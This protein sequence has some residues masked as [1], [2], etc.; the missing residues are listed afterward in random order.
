M[1]A[2]VVTVALLAGGVLAQQKN[3]QDIDLQAAI[4]TETVDGDLNGAIKQYGAIVSK[5]K[6]DR[7]VAATALVRMAGCYQKLGDAQARTI[8]ER[9]VREFGD[10]RDAVEQ[11]RARLGEQRS[12]GT[13]MVARQLWTTTFYSQVTIANDGRSAAVAEPSSRD[14]QIRDFTTGQT[15][16]LKVT[17]NPASGAYAEWPVLSP[18]LKQVAYAY[19]GPETK[20]NYQVRIA[21][22]QPDAKARPVGNTSPYLYV[23]GWSPDGRSVLVTILAEGNN[24]Q[25][26]W[27]STTDGAV[28]TLKS[29]DWQDPER[30][31]LSPDGKFIAYAVMVEQGKPDREIRI[32]ASD[33]SSESVV[34]RAPGINASPVWSRDGSRLVFM[35]D[36]SGTLGIWSVA[37]RNGRGDG[38]PTRLKADVGDIALIGFDATGSLLYEHTIGMRDVFAMDL[39]SQAGK[40]HGDAVRLLDTFL[41]WNW[42]PAASPDG[43]SL[44][45]LSRRNGTLNYWANLVVR[46]LETGAERVIPTLFRAAGAGG[47]PVWLPDGQSII[48]PARNTQGHTILYKVDLKS[49]EIATAINTASQTPVT[50]AISPD[51]RTVY[52]LASGAEH[53]L[54]AAYD[55]A[56][57]RRTDV[58]HAGNAKSVAASPDGRSIAFVAWESAR[59][60]I[61]A[62][63]TDGRNVHAIVTTERPDERPSGLAGGLS[64]SP[65]S[66]FVFFLQQDQGSLWRVAAIGGA[67]ALVGELTKDPVRTIDVTRD[68]RR[69]IFSTDRKGDSVEVWALDNVLPSSV[70]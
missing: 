70:R 9:V 67:A 69:V 6:A 46:S 63:D 59:W 60:H 34:A 2:F 15:T 47:T 68:G 31:A 40:I 62:A 16:R 50:A 5:Y 42:N 56:S 17:P 13:G 55:L 37:V 26:A 30:L 57:G 4:R 39:D 14:V 58:S 7:G 22:T 12:T 36:R 8:Y 53:V 21:A 35:S 24:F 27:M 32:L 18:D 61:Y 25:I 3:Q 43:K 28:R 51:G 20:F 38:S 52:A 54:V 45:Y 1:T 10:Q 29:L 19:A 44:A 23:M 48:Q 65:D 66:R 11:A 41:G 49:G 64:W 33:A